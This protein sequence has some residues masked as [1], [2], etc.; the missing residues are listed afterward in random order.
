M[1]HGIKWLVSV[2]GVNYNPSTARKESICY[3]L[4]LSLSTTR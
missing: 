1:L 2:K 4:S 3:C